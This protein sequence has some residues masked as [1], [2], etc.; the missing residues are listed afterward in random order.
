M[1]KWARVT[2]YS[3]YPKS[4]AKLSFMAYARNIATFPLWHFIFVFSPH[5]SPPTSKKGLAS[6]VSN[7][8]PSFHVPLPFN[9][10][11]ISLSPLSLP[12]QPSVP[13]LPIN[14]LLYYLSHQKPS[15]VIP[16]LCS[17]PSHRNPQPLSFLSEPPVPI[18]LVT[19][20][21]PYPSNQ[22]HPASKI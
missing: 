15:N 8:H 21:Q 11:Y 1:G 17:Y 14:T 16:P 10:F 9:P 19:T 13:L 22:N 5:V 2:Y 4:T 3:L 6:R 18:P 20:L 7:S 12:Q